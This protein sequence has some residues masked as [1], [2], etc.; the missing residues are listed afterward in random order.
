MRFC[1]DSYFHPSKRF[2]LTLYVVGGIRHR[3]A[4]EELFRGP[5]QDHT[6]NFVPWWVINSHAQQGQVYC[7]RFIERLKPIY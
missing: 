7:V 5:V 4:L 6:A 2:G 1:D 3:Y